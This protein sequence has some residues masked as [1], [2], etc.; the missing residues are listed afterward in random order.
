MSTSSMDIASLSNDQ[1]NQ[2]DNDV[3]KASSSSGSESWLKYR[4]ETHKEI[5]RRR[6]DLIN[7]GINELSKL[8]PN[9]EKNK[10]RIIMRA[11]EYILDL[12]TERA[13]HLE[14]CNFEKMIS[15]DTIAHLHA[16]MEYFKKNNEQTKEQLRKV[17]EEYE[18]DRERL[19]SLQSQLDIYLDQDATT[20][21]T[22]PVPL[23]KP[24]VTETQESTSPIYPPIYNYSELFT[25]TVI[26]FTCDTGISTSP[27]KASES[28][29]I[30]VAIAAEIQKFVVI[31]SSHDSGCPE[32]NQDS[33]FEINEAM[34]RPIED[35]NMLTEHLSSDIE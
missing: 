25:D 30:E 27:Q 21:A 4:K 18:K 9:Q 35:S 19:K 14:K 7:E 10:G 26:P 13:D 8:I 22:N 24:A 32:R 34:F 28:S 3:R 31:D 11:V 6:R 1:Q 17:T 16:S 15:A 20:S 29:T 33:V 23:S 12:Q 5:E 2:D